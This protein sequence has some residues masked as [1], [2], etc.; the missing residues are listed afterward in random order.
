MRPLSPSA[1]FFTPEMLSRIRLPIAAVTGVLIFLVGFCV[2]RLLGRSL[3]VLSLAFLAVEPFLLSESRRA[4]TDAL[5]A[6]FLFL[7]LLL[8]LCYLEGNLSR[9]RDIVGSGISFG[10]ACL[11]KSYAMPFLL[12]VP[13]V[14][15]WY[16]KQ[17]TLSLPRLLWSTLLWLMVVLA[18]VL[19]VFPHMWMQSLFLPLCGM[20][21]VMILWS[22]QNVSRPT[23]PKLTRTART[24]LFG[25]LVG[26]IGFTLAV[27]GPIFDRM[28][29][30]LTEAHDLPKL[31]LGDI[32]SNPGW[33]YFP[34]VWGV[35][36][37]TLT[38]PLI[39]VALYSTW[40]QRG[41]KERKTFR[42]TVVLAMF[43]L[44]YLLGLSI[45]AKKI[46][47]YQVIF[48]PAVTLLAA[49]GG[50]HIAQRFPKKWFRYVLLIA[51]FALQA[52]P[53]LRLHPYY[54]AYYHP[55][56]S[57]KWVAE[58]TTCIT[59]LG[60]EL[61]AEYL[62]TKP[63]AE[64]L[65]AR[66]T[67][68]SKDFG[69]YFAG[70]TLQRHHPDATTDHHFDYDIEYLRD[71]QVAGKTPI[72]APENYQIHEFLRLG[73]KLPR[74]PEPEHVVRLNGIDYVWIY[75]VT[76]PTSEDPPAMTEGE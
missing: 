13:L 48:L 11:T 24:V 21:S 75:R 25:I 8:W 76:Q 72:D 4:H 16:L 40:H 55:L 5:T 31:F 12:F 15:V 62:N 69:R 47:R 2:Y 26:I 1:E 67:W 61:A 35:W 38:L 59:G 32:L 23:P 56:L 34:M 63:D 53:V 19:V 42:I 44:F 33:L 74:A 28:F 17:N 9:R 49:I 70:E 6:L 73:T 57:G 22:W 37:G 51:V 65:Q 29:W 10:L 58:N 27:G 54:R 43:M 20:N 7:S 18:T 60:L 46:S 3:A 14:L 39:G 52:L 66:L 68:F 41:L 50:T 71:K 45:V 64:K 30:A 36:S